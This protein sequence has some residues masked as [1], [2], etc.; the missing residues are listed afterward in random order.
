MAHTTN[1]PKLLILKTL[2]LLI[3]ISCSKTENSISDSLEFNEPQVMNIYCQRDSN[4]ILKSLEYTYEGNNLVSKT[5]LRNGKIISKYEFEYNAKDLLL[6]EIY[7]ST[8]SKTEKSYF[9]NT[10]DQLTNIKYK[11]TQFNANGE[12]LEIKEYEEPREYEN[13]LLIKEWK[14]WGGFS[15]YEYNQGKVSTKI[16]YTKNGIEHHFTTYKYSENLLIQE[17]KETKVGSLLYLKTFVYDSDNRLTEVLD[18]EN[19]IEEYDYVNGKL[20]EK[21]TYYFG[22]DPG[23]D[24]CYGNYIYRFEY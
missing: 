5:T 13:N 18:R 9:Y 10:L 12:I 15:T 4:T 3:L 7:T 11:F 20:T 16:D 17:K 8:L 6:F 2:A 22:I 21:R 24:I 1:F 23:Y 14:Y 19:T